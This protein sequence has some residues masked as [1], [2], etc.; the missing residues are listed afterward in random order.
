[1][2]P[3]GQRGRVSLGQCHWLDAMHLPHQK[4]PWVKQSHQLRPAPTGLD[5]TALYWSPN[6]AMEDEETGKPLPADAGLSERMGDMTK[7]PGR[8][9]SPG[10]GY[11]QLCRDAVYME[12]NTSE[13]GPLSA[14]PTSDD[15]IIE[16]WGTTYSP[17][18]RWPAPVVLPL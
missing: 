6:S 9:Y 12:P 16:P 10:P 5:G 17:G 7:G 3:R 15:A 13:P 8:L 4:A 1:M 2:V 18:P 11:A 14:G